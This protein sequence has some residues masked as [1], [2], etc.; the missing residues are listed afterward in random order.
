MFV[1]QHLTVPSE[2]CNVTGKYEFYKRSLITK[3]ETILLITQ[4]DILWDYNSLYVYMYISVLSIAS[5][6]IYY[7]L[8]LYSVIRYLT[9]LF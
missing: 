1:L 7:W 8:F 5:G 2:T 6:N 4:L 3:M 9:K